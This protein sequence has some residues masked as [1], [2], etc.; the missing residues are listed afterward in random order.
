MVSRPT[1]LLLGSRSSISVPFRMP[2][3]RRQARHAPAGRPL[4][5]RPRQGLPPHWRSSESRGALDHRADDVPRDGHELLAGGG[6]GGD[7]GVGTR[8]VALI[9]YLG[10]EKGNDDRAPAGV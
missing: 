4:P 5:P 7:S 2:G 6:G 10:L 9:P 8:V 3:P 1:G